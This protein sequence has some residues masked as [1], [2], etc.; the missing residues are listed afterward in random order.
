MTLREILTSLRLRLDDLGADAGDW[1]ADDSGL[2]WT[3]DELA[4][5]ASEAQLELTRRVPLVDS[6]TASVCQVAL[7]AGSSGGYALDPR[8]LSVERVL[9]D[10]EPLTKVFHE[11]VDYGDVTDALDVTYYHADIDEHRLYI[12][13]APTAD[14][15]AN[16]TVHRTAIQEFLAYDANAGTTL[17]SNAR[18]KEAIVTWAA[19]LALLKRDSEV[20]NPELSGRYE[21]RFTNMVGPRVSTR[22]ERVRERFANS[23]LRTRVYY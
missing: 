11:D 8:I 9:V 20:F 19:S 12:Y 1:E 7:T 21:G 13:K 10:G 15:T 17:E 16:L 5:Y 2:K 18:H 6:Q 3:N 22:V 4:Y 23:K 14:T